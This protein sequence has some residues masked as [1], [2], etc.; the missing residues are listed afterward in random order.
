MDRASRTFLTGS[1]FFEGAGFETSFGAGFAFCAAALDSG[2]NEGLSEASAFLGAF[3][4]LT[5]AHATMRTSHH[6]HAVHHD[7]RSC[8]P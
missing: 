8:Y 4:I 7:A 6:S 5:P 2:S 3:R 1:G